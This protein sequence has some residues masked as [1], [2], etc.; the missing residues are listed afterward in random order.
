M[1][2]GQAF[3]GLIDDVRLSDV[4]L[5]AEQLL[6]TSAGVNEHT[7]GYWKFENDPGPYKDSSPRGHDIATHAATGAR[8]DAPFAALVDF[9]HVLL[10]S[11]EFLYVD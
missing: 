9:C 4:P 11:N 1:T 8:E 10:N 5:V 2:S 6:F 3:D 7:V